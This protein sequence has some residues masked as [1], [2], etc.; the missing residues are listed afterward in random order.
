MFR[1]YFKVA[2]RNLRNNKAFATLNIVGLAIGMATAILI[3]LWIFDELGYDHYNPNHQKLAQVLITQS[4]NGE[5]Y[6]G[7]TI[8]MP[9]GAAIQ[10]KYAD[11]FEK[12]ALV[13]FHDTHVLGLKEKKL[14][15]RGIFSQPDFPSMLGLHIIHGSDN[16]LKDPS[17]LMIAQS[18]AV[19]LFGNESALNKTLLLD[20]K[21][22]MK[23]GAVYEDLPENS[24]FSETVLLLPWTNPENQYLNTSTNWDDH[25]GNLFVLLNDHTTPTQATSRIKNIPTPFIKE[26]NEEALVYSNDKMHLYGEF[27]NG[28]PSG[29]RI[30]MVTLIGII[31]GFVLFLAC[32]NF[33]NL[34]TARSSKRAKEVGIRKTI[35]SLP[36]HL[37]SQFLIESI[38]L[39]LFAFV[40]SI[41]IVQFSLPFFNRIS[42]KHMTVPY[43]NPWFW[44]LS[45]AFAL[46]TGIISGSYPAFYLSSF[47]PIKVLKG[48][49]Q[50]SR[51]NSIPRQMMVVMQ[52]TV[53]LSLIIG[54]IIV[55]RQ[56]IYAKNRPTGYTREGLVTMPL[57]ADL[58]GHYDALRQDLLRTGAVSEMAESSQP[59]TLFNNN[60]SMNWRGK[61]PELVVY[62]RNVN[63]TTEFGKTVGWKI[64]EG[65]DFSR[66]FA[67]SNSIILSEG[68]VKAIGIEH[69]VGEIVQFGGKNRTV[70]GVTQDLLTNSPYETIEPA[71][72][73]GDGYMSVITVRMKPGL[74]LATAMTSIEKVFKKYNPGSPFIFQYN[75]DAYANKFI[76]EERVGNLSAVFA[77]MAIFISCLGLFGLA[78][79]VA[80]QRTKEIGVRKVLGAT[81]FSLWSMLST[82]FVKLVLISL[83]I[84][85]PL[86]YYGM[87]QWLQS[88]T[89]RDGISVW[90]F[91]VA[92][93]SILLITLLTV[94]YQS[95]K[96]ALMNPV[97]SLRSE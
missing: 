25:N 75:D 12:I 45:I 5:S 51:Y 21:Q 72:F 41:L 13:S 42:G 94:S 82:Q 67:D 3:G 37:I 22:S 81:M 79:F 80:E 38:L 91:V 9:L 44:L 60:N 30:Q 68:A 71:I 55:Y 52:F 65:R 47:E 35:G 2:I 36:I 11:L 89:Y 53:S 48:A 96:A 1:N 78:S 29:G 16:A 88:Y 61:D 33:M 6:T 77:G 95:I 90:I 85:I 92:G 28:K 31:G 50:G 17:T 10:S 40:I 69:P 46:F 70:I 73:L 15:G 87:N 86:S 39:T 20:N 43:F 7:S 18:L 56:I 66:E 62:F 49:F 97:K 83:C 26:V 84:S 23:V 64:K 57:S 19:S 58:Y 63:V 59:V 27:K 24:S 93:V 32:I 4:K 74:P 8:A 14:S 34:S 54:T 76:S